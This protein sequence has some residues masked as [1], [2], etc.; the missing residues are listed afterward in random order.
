MENTNQLNP[1]ES[2]KIISRV[3]NQTRENIKDQSFYFLWWGWIITIA[4]FGH[5][6]LTVFSD[7]DNSHI[8]WIILIPIGW[9]GSIV[10][11]IKKEK[12]KSYQT[13]FELFL[14]YLWI[15]LGISFMI[16]VFISLSL[17]VQPA[18]FVLLLAGIGTLVSGLTMKFKPLIIGGLLFFIFAIGSLFVNQTTVLLLNAIAIVTGYLIPAYFLKN[19]K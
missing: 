17:D 8:P 6:F 14:K 10:Y 2:L 12:E 11:S 9:V 18:I 3:I 4:A 1:N 13:Y 5:Y 7:T 15:V 19:S 16:S